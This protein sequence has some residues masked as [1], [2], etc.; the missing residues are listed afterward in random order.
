MAK[1]YSED[2]DNKKIDIFWEREDTCVSTK[3]KKGRREK[4]FQYIYTCMI[5]EESDAPHHP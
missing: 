3:N 4:A 2:K 1:S 5:D